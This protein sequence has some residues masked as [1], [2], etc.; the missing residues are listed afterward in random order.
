VTPTNP[1][2]ERRL[3]AILCADIA[4]YS[5]LM[6]DAEEE[7]VRTVTACLDLFRRHIAMFGGRVVDTAGD[8]VLSE[9]PSAVNAVRFAISIQK[10]L[11][12]HNGGLPEHRRAEFRIGVNL[13]DIIVQNQSI[14]GDAVNVA[15]RL[16]QLSIPNGI[17]ISSTVYHQVCNK[18]PAGFECLGEQVL[19]NI[20]EPVEVWRVRIE[21]D[22]ALFG[23]TVRKGKPLPLPSRPSIAVLPFANLTRNPAE[24]YFSDGLSED[25]ITGLSRFKELFVIARNSS[26][27]FKTKSVVAQEAG[28]QLGVR[29][30]L[31]GS[32][33]HAGNRVRV[34]AQLVDAPAGHPIWAERYDRDITDLFAVQDEITQLIVAM[35][36]GHVAEAERSRMKRN[37][38]DDLEAYHSFLRGQEALFLYD[39][40]GNALAKRM[41][42]Q[43]IAIDSH[44]S[45]AYAGLARV[46]NYDWQF[47]WSEDSDSS[48]GK[49]VEFARRAVAL[50]DSNSRAH[51]ELG[52]S[53]LFQKKTERAIAEL[54][55][56]LSLNPNDADIMAELADAYA[57]SSRAEEAVELLKQAMR[58]NPHYPD[59]YLWYLAD[60]FYAL[61]RYDEAVQALERMHN[62]SAGQRLLAASCAQ[63]GNQHRAAEHAAE[64]L[65][66]QPDFSISRWA[67]KQPEKDSAELQHLIEGLRKAGLPE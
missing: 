23:P 14:Y 8:G 58:L 59:F 29:Y 22:G 18:L 19:K 57:Y 52:Y 63:M 32:V 40:E 67:Q 47:G 11:R 44:Y 6:G 46:Y 16:E 37:E 9:F 25:I 45:R 50:D 24:E 48:L 28:R 4:G 34:S 36:V 1:E 5:R 65:R 30:L 54:Q 10:E 56:A 35:L 39:K 20:E 27:V 41:Y 38:T 33:R 2:Y 3:A 53:L 55:R 17:C 62:P 51:S 49:S 64:V 42:E 26:F 12:Q 66:L 13:G 15:A 60:A 21:E 43:A 31:E 61:R 7:T